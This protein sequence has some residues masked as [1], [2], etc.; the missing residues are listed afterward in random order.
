MYIDLYMTLMIKLNLGITFPL[1]GWT[2]LTL[3]S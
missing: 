1:F 2:K 3:S